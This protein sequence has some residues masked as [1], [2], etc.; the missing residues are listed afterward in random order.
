MRIVFF[1]TPEFAVPSLQTLITEGHEVVA[2]VTQP[3]KSRGRSRSVLVPPPIKT[4][5]LEHGLSVLQPDRPTGDLFAAALQ[6]L[7]PE[8]GVVGGYRPRHPPEIHE[9]PARGRVNVHSHNN[10][11]C[12]ARS[13]RVHLPY[14]IPN[15]RGRH[16]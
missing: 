4:L 12:T 5:S 2:V 10:S 7:R 14:V 9:P 11:S 15:I 8:I 6:R 13:Q 1:G 16:C 3:D